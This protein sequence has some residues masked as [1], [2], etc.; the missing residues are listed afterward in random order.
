MRA[1]ARIVVECDPDGRSRLTDLYAQAPFSLRPCSDAVYLISSAQGLLGNDQLDI[2]VV[3]AKG[4]SLILRSVAATI[5]YASSGARLSA[6]V[7]VANGGSLD[8]HLEPLIATNRCQ[9]SIEAHVDLEATARLSWTEEAIL[10]REDELPGDL[11]LLLDVDR[12]SRP[13]LRHHL[14]ISTQSG[15]QGPAVLGSYR[16]TGVRLDVGSS[17]PQ[18][19]TA[20]SGGAMLV[21]DDDAFLTCAVGRNL[22]EMRDRLGQARG[23]IPETQWKPKDHGAEIGIPQPGRLVAVPTKDALARK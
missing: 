20:V 19:V 22:I 16:A 12:D 7:S 5:A 10:G 3:V 21:I 4:A 11:S 15:W 13:F 18:P 1:L 6:N 8:W 9:A 2:E 23:G 17:P 14:D